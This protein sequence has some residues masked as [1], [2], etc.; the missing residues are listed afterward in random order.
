MMELDGI[1]R[2]EMDWEGRMQSLRS[3]EKKLSID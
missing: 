1:N 3:P 2:I